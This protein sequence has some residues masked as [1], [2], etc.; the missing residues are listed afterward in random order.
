MSKELVTK[1]SI[2]KLPYK[3]TPIEYSESNPFCPVVVSAPL[4]KNL[5]PLCPEITTKRGGSGR[6]GAIIP[7][8]NIIA[9]PIA[10]GGSITFVICDELGRYELDLVRDIPH[11]L[12]I[13]HLGFSK[14]IDQI[15]ISENT[16]RDFILRESTESLKEVIIEQQMAVIVKKI[17]SPAARFHHQLPLKC[18]NK[19]PLHQ[20]LAVF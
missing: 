1:L 9:S 4:N 17:P 8:T 15:S 11:K 6:L 16:T 7:H 12:E 13:T 2:C 14:G 10:D 5:G 20:N 18:Q 3:F 19:A